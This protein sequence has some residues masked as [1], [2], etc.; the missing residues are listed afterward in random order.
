MY[1]SNVTHTT[2]HATHLKWW[3]I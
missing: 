2:Q 3:K 1:K